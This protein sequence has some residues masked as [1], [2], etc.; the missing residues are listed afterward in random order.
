MI[1][2]RKFGKKVIAALGPTNTGK[3]HYAVEKM[4][5]HSNGMIGLPLRLLAREVYEKVVKRSGKQSVA[6]VTGEERIVPPNPKYWICTVEAMPVRMQLDFLAVDEIQMCADLDRGHVFTER[7]LKSRG[8]KETIFLGSNSIR[9]VLQSVL[10]DVEVTSKK[11]LSK[12][13]YM[14]SRKLSRIPPRSAIVCFSVEEVYSIAELIRREK[15]GAAIVTGGLSPRTRNSQV[16]VY[17][18]GEVDYL[19]A[20]DAIG[21]GLNLDIKNVAFAS[22][23]KFDGF[24]QRNL[25][26]NELAQIAGRAGRY[27]SDGTFGV[28]AG[29]QDLNPDTIHRIENHIFSDI[30]RL[31]WRNSD[32]CFE[33]LQ[34]LIGSL[35]QKS[36][37]TNLIKARESID[38][39]ALAVMAATPLVA[40]RITSKPG[41]QLLWKI[42]QIPDYRKISLSDHVQILQEIFLLISNHGLIPEEW[43]EKKIVTLDKYDGGIDGLSQR[44]AYI[45]TWNYVSNRGDWLEKPQ[46]LQEKSRII[47]DKLS[48]HLHQLLI[49]QFVDRRTTILMRKIREK[50]TLTADL[51]EK[52]ELFVE[53]QLIGTL[54]GFTFLLDSSETPHD[55]KRLLSVSRQAIKSKL[56]FLVDQLYECPDGDFFLNNSGSVIW[57]DSIVG[58]LKSGNTI[59]EPEIEPLIDEMATSTVREKLV[60]RLRYFLDGLIKANLSSLLTLVDDQEIS[61]LSAGLVFR[62]GESLGIVPRELVSKD[63]KELDQ[64]TRSKFRKHGV[65]FGQY[66]VFQ[67][68]LLKPEPSRIRILL[69]KIYHKPAL[70]PE[71]PVPGLVT[72]PSVKGIDPSFYIMA[73]FRML[74]TRAVRIDML[75]RLADLIRNEDA[76]NGFEATPEML[77]ITGLT[78]LQFKDLVGSLGYKASTLKKTFSSEINGSG[79]DVMIEKNDPNSGGAKGSP[80]MKNS[81][82]VKEPDSVGSESFLF[83][84][85]IKRPEIRKNR[86][87]N[88]SRFKK[89]GNLDKEIEQPKPGTRVEKSRVK[90]VDPN[91]PFAALASLMKN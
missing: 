69:W 72:I 73:G 5:C 25:F 27:M 48:D 86:K 32:L 49:E 77:S 40:D 39:R 64:E 31:Q 14:D 35:E 56:S 3:T 90:K 29:C 80:V 9:S 16:Q 19:V 83:K 88:V 78:L 76:K 33:D 36:K 47:E 53:N 82:I 24:S 21:M 65:R 71:P 10:P 84:F 51:N 42:C 22:L 2:R 11:R 46:S 13:F 17:Q 74:G 43:L 38:Q 75:E 61:G 85:D 6:L 79:Q 12:L 55:K 87:R 54:E 28:T 26:P 52:G 41:V 89:K 68:S 91:S 30:K 57:R 4:L 15:G 45:R 1:S 7:L 67:P 58:S 50:V 62:L 23:S 59:L 37:Q 44:L 66:S 34:C 63:V 18:D 70:V 81:K 8:T 60:R 20:T